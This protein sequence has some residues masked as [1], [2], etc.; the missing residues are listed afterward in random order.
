MV[1]QYVREPLKTEE[2]DRLVNTCRD[3]K[4]KLV[5]W[6]LL[7]TGLRISELCSLTDTHVIEEFQQKW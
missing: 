6:T 2:A 3:T 4:E 1:Y 7:D 5:V